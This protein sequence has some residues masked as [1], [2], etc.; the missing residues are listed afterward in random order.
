MTRGASAS[1]GLSLVEV[2]VAL[3]ILSMVGLLIGASLRGVGNSATKVD[4]RV[5]AVDQ[6]RVSAS[7][8]RELLARVSATSLPGPRR[9]PGQGRL[10]EPGEDHVAWISVMP[11][12]FG[13]VGR[14]AFRLSIEPVPDE[15]NCLVLRFA[16]MD[17]QG[18]ALPDWGQ[19]QMRILARGAMQL[20]VTYGGAGL[21]SGWVSDWSR[22]DELPP[23]LR[24]DVLLEQ[25]AWPPI[26]LPVRMMMPPKP[27][28]TLGGGS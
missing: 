27:L 24:L 16:P 1:R 10:F 15:G 8:L 19:A 17:G 21:G 2:L 18:A 14:Y 3:S 7:F 20:R 4:A 9:E 6:L 12:R 11:A 22:T 5:N 23:R 28:F 25:G 26:V 13:A